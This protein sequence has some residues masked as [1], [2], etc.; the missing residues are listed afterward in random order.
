MTFQLMLLPSYLSSHA[1]LMMRKRRQLRKQ[2]RKLLNDQGNA[3][4]MVCFSLLRISA[5]APVQQA[6]VLVLSRFQ[7]TTGSLTKRWTTISMLNVNL[8]SVAERGAMTILG[9]TI[10]VRKTLS[11]SHHVI[12]S[13]LTAP[14]T[15][16]CPRCAPHP[17]IRCCD[18]CHP[19]YFKFAVTDPSDKAPKPPRKLMPKAYER[20]P[21]EE[22]L[23]KD[24]V[25]L[26]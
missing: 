6:R 2:P 14:P 3:P 21:A 8:V 18:I 25:S 23:R 11:P 22:S 4:W 26:R 1:I 24:L 15:P 7:V 17:V 13:S 5:V 12:C 9:T 10:S 16:C 20:G 19:T